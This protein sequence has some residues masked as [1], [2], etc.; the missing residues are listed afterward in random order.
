CMTLSMSLGIA[1]GA[2]RTRWMMAGELLGVGIV[3]T[4][5]VV[6]AASLMLHY[7]LAFIVLKWGGGAYLIWLGVQMWLS[8]GRLALG[9][10]NSADNPTTTSRIQL[11][12]QGFITAIA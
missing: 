6:G 12:S 9:A 11:F 1:I 8:Q 2:R 10:C 3:A 5:A 4:S 7:P